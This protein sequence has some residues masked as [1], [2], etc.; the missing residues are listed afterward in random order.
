MLTPDNVKAVI[1]FAKEHN[2][3][4]FADEVY[5]DNIYPPDMKFVS[6]KKVSDRTWMVP[7]PLNHSTHIRTHT[8][9]VP[10]K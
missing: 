4:M 10:Q 5:Q 6:F 2:L 1:Q 3:F 7:K 8:D 9:S